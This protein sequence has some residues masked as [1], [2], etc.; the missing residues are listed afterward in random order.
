MEHDSLL[1]VCLIE[2]HILL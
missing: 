2:N 1:R